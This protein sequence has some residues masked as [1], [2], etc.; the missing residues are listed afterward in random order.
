[1]LNLKPALRELAARSE[2][3][4]EFARGSYAREALLRIG[5]KL[6]GQEVDS[7]VVK[8]A[9][10]KRPHPKFSSPEYKKIE[11][12]FGINQTSDFGDF[13]MK[14][15]RNDA[16]SKIRNA[17]KTGALNNMMAERKAQRALPPSPFAKTTTW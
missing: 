16:A 13:A 9:L 6:P 11:V 17:K 3:I 7:S 14:L 12:P 15:I 5:A 1:M 10:I 2:Q 8:Y 4:T